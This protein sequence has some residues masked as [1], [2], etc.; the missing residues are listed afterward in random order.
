MAD[1]P[2]RQDNVNAFIA[3]M[4][5]EEYYRILDFA[6]KLLSNGYVLDKTFDEVVDTLIEKEYAKADGKLVINTFMPKIDK[7][8]PEDFEE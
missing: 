4:G 6:G 1:H 7:I 5:Q 2:S 3:A 8:E